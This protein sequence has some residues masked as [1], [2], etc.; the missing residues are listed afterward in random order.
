MKELKGLK[1]DSTAVDFY[2]SFN[3]NCK[4]VGWISIKRDV[5]YEFIKILTAFPLEGKKL[6]YFLSLT[7]KSKVGYM[8]SYIMKLA[9]KMQLPKIMIEHFQE[10]KEKNKM[11]KKHKPDAQ[12]VAK[13]LNTD[14]KSFLREYSWVV[15]EEYVSAQLN[16]ET[17]N[18]CSAVIE[19]YDKARQQMIKEQQM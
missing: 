6:E 14:I 9:R 10:L 12:E 13:L 17:I 16:N 18:L 2:E 4:V 11:Y 5:Y 3:H 19:K 1:I 15:K 7:P 8:S